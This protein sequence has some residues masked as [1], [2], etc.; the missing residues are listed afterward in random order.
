MSLAE[1]QKVY[2]I[3]RLLITTALEETWPKD[4]ETPVLFLG[5]WCR[6][7]SKKERWSIMNSEIVPYHWDD[8]DKLYNDY[9]YLNNL[10]EIKLR[11]VQ[12]QLNKIHGVDYSLRYWRILI[13]PW[14]GYFIQI[15]FDR[16]AM[17]KHAFENYEIS[18]CRVLEFDGSPLIP[19]GMNDCLNL[20]ITD[21]WNEMIYSQLLQEHLKYDILIEPLRKDSIQINESHNNTKSLRYYISKLGGLGAKSLMKIKSNFINVNEYFFLKTYLPPLIEEK[22]LKRLGQ[23]PKKWKLATIPKIQM[24]HKMREWKLKMDSVTD[25]FSNIL[26]NMISKHIP[27]V[28]LEGYKSLYTNTKYLGWPESPKCIFTSVSY[29][30]NDI[31]KIWAAEKTENGVPLVIG[32]H[33]GNYGMAPWS[34]HE[35]QQISISDAWLS[36]G[37]CDEKKPEIIPACNLKVINHA[38]KYNPNG[39]ALMVEVALPRYSSHMYTVPIA[40]Q[41]LSYFEDQ[42]RFISALPEHVRKKI[43]IRLYRDD[44]GWCQEDR[45]MQHFPNIKL[46][47]GQEPIHNLVN[48][49]RICISTY[50]ATTFL[51]SLSWNM[52]TIIFWN[53]SYWELRAS[54]IP[55]FEL[56]KSANI[57]HETP[58]S[59]ANHMTKIWDD[60]PAWWQSKSVQ[61]NRQKFCDQ[62]SLSLE[63]P[64]D[65]LE[66]IF[67]NI[68]TKAKTVL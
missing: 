56:L 2:F 25:D 44:M 51:E 60:I 49:S 55:Y 47:L 48:R 50:N 9:Q 21:D 33:G 53:P 16:W 18:S 7:Y 38:V 36:W 46:E 54:A 35:E 5:E 68:S 66:T 10:Y 52:P 6:I 34:F 26:N 29:S 15:V 8:R 64:L 41:W 3:S 22:L 37:W 11:A 43:L 31:F 1:C 17:L 42:C 59:A 67:Q 4:S 45:W 13:G 32:Q 19:N 61:D 58:E 14:L 23:K 30:D 24:N 62:Y 12:K 57:F 20:F 63:N 27:I 40:S 39:M 28:Y 65:R